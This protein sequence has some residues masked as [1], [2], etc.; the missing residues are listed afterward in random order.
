MSPG[1]TDGFSRGELPPSR[2]D[3]PSFS[4]SSQE[5]DFHRPNSSSTSFG[6]AKPGDAKGFWLTGF[7]RVFR[8]TLGWEAG[9]ES[10]F[11]RQRNNIQGNGWQF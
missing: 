5:L 9:I 1:C 3:L 10:R 4:S 7:R 2:A 6:K 8:K 11:Q